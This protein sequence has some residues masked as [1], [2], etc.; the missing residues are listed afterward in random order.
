[1]IMILDHSENG[2]PLRADSAQPE[3]AAS[4][5]V[6]RRRGSIFVG[7]A[8]FSARHKQNYWFLGSE[9]RAAL[10]NI[11]LPSAPNQNGIQAMTNIRDFIDRKDIRNQ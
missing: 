4:S 5:A 9:A 1:M 6:V 2:M 11:T 10:S 8:R 7:C 3:V